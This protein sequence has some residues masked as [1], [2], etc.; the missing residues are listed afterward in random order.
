[1]KTCLSRCIALHFTKKFLT[2]MA[3][4]TIFSQTDFPALL[5]WQAIAFMRCEWPGIFK[6]DLRFLS[7]PYS[8]NMTTAHFAIHEGDS[9]ISYATTLTLRLLH[10]GTPYQK[11]HLLAGMNPASDRSKSPQRL[12]SLVAEATCSCQRPNSIGAWCQKFA[13][14]LRV[15]FFA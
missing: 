11:S 7:E 14:P 2:Q 13:P 10:A 5:K 3:T 1:M 6:G 9:L 4:L 12:G 8:P 15:E